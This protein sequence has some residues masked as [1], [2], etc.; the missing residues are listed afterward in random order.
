[1]HNSYVCYY[2]FPLQQ[3]LDQTKSILKQTDGLD[4][5]IF[6]LKF[7]FYPA[8]P[9]LLPQEMT[10]YLIYLQLRLDLLEGR[11]HCHSN[12]DLAY[13][14][15]CILQCEYNHTNNL[16]VQP[17]EFGFAINLNLCYNQVEFLSEIFYS[18]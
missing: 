11:L 14:I 13:I 9:A 6:E 8:E 5:I 12:E 17:T 3:W 7:K 15:A 16:H 10:R 18:D 4:P 2:S 1:M